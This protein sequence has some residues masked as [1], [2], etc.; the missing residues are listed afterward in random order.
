MRDKASRSATCFAWN[1]LTNYPG[2]ENLET[3]MERG[4]IVMQ[5]G[6]SQDT[7]FL[8]PLST[9]CWSKDSEMLALLLPRCE[10]SSD[11]AEN[12]VSWQQAIG[13]GVWMLAIAA[14]RRNLQTE[15]RVPGW[16]K[17]KARVNQRKQASRI[18]MSLCF[19]ACFQHSWCLQCCGIAALGV[20]QQ[21]VL[22]GD[23]KSPRFSSRFG[24]I[25]QCLLPVKLSSASR[26]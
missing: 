18:R 13:S 10:V 12:T 6:N 5:K 22:W 8:L 1:S 20:W 24:E 23:R 4:N 3:W 26:Y 25:Q 9:C 15:H 7:L 21:D 2:R 14:K 19:T 17:K 11:E 16:K